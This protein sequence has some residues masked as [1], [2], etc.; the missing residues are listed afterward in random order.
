MTDLR[1]AVRALR[2]SPGFSLVAVLTIAVGI[3]ANTA[4]FSVYDRLVL[5][6]VTIPKP[7]SLVAIWI[8][9]PQLNFNAPAM[10]WPRYEDT[11]AHATSFDAVGISA[12]DNFTLTGNGDPEQLNGQRVS[13]SFLPTLGIMP[14]AGRNFTEDEDLPNGPAVCILS[15]ELWQTRFGGRREIVGST[16]TLNG[17]PWQV[18]GVLPPRLSPPFAQV[19]VLAPRVFEVGGLTP[20]QVQNGAGYAQPIARLKTGVSLEQAASEL[21]ALGRS[22]KERFA[23]RLDANNAAEPRMYVAALVGNLQPT[24]YTLL[25]AVSFVLLIACANVASLFLGRLTA[26]VRE[27]AVRQALGATRRRVMQQF[28]IESLVFSAA[29]GGLGV[30]IAMWGLNAIQSIIAT[31]LPPNTTLT[32]N[33]RA[34]AFTGVVTLATSLLVGVVPALQ[35]SR[36]ELVETLKDSARGSS[37]ERSGRFRAVLIVAEVALSV[38]L[39]VGSAL[40]LIS[41]VAL[42]RTPPG[43][44]PRGAATAFV[45]VPAA[46]YGTPAQQAQFFNE[47]IARLDAQPQVS[48]AAAVIGLPLSGFNPRSPY[49]VGGRPILPLP[50]RP[51]ANLGIVSDDYF[52][53][54][55]MTFAAGRAFNAG[56]REGA[57][58]VCVINE[59]L[60]KRLFPGESAIG[61]IMLRGRDAELKAEVVGVIHDVKTNGLNV[62]APDEIYYPIRQL[63]RPGM[64]IVARTDGDAAALQPILRSTVAAV[65][66]DQ[67]ISFFATLETN[68]AQ[69]LGVQRIVASLTSI[70]AGLALVLSAIGL[71]SVLAYAVSQRTPEIGIRMALGAR[72][73]QVVR[74]VLRDGLRLVIVGLVAGLAAAAGAA[75][76]IETLLFG[77]RPLDPMVYGGVAGVFT[78]V[79]IVACL[80]PSLRASR[81]DPLL[82][83]RAE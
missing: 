52:T 64:A 24:F 80:V 27:V 70:F 46:R 13:A 17:Q 72:P 1:N 79:A 23:S 22:Y 47:V 2:K 7:A 10:S 54:M 35:A 3:G 19:Q 74:L 26:R 65:D 69:S 37:S 49:S 50:Q 42:Q 11:R 4:L 58:G 63:P 12:F 9:N 66:K 59:S 38:V 33:W 39:L 36:T 67:P 15:H 29:A 57:P 77:V 16:I 73:G 18:V 40:L 8:N 76:L 55:R 51:I 75:R 48:G 30:L 34:L 20:I 78:I 68:V 62:P 25:G 45:G 83:L 32:L 21:A 5:N 53:V 82:A 61:K 56:D 14:A 43:F 60:A 6:P 41:F 44:E 81:I 71:Y 31:Q 28:L